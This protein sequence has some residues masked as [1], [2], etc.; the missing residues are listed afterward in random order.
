MISRII[1]RLKLLFPSR[2]GKVFRRI[3]RKNAWGSA[4]SISGPG[5]TLAYTASLRKE[6]PALL[7]S[8]NIKKLLDAPCGDFNWISHIDLKGIEYTGADIVSELIESNKKKYPGKKF[9][10][11]DLIRDVLPATD[12]IVCR[13]CFIHLQ[14]RDVIRAIKNFKKT[15]AK[16]ILAS[17]YPVNFNK[18]ILTGHFREVNMQLP[19]FN[20]PEPIQKLKDYAEGETERYLGLWLLQEI[21]PQRR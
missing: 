14:T 19:P 15:G 11:A 20:F 3:Y 8:L 18:E 4:E 5:S 6:L 2:P 1:N 9:M 13:D 12:L 16:Y 7:H 17:T 21:F 10:V